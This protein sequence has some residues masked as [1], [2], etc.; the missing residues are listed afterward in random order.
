MTKIQLARW[1]AAKNLFQSLKDKALLTD[2]TILF[3]LEP[4][5]PEQIEITD[6]EINIKLGNCTYNQFIADP[7][8]DEGLQ[9]SIKTFA[10]NT[11]KN[12][13]LVKFLSW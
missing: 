4:I 6:T 9:D 12:I 13:K 8:L 11:K 2:C 1:T 5:A 7:G 10:E 3:Y